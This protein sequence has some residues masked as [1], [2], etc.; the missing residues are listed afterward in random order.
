MKHIATLL[1]C[2]LILLVGCGGNSKSKQY[3]VGIDAS[4]HS[5]DLEGKENNVTAFSTDLLQEIGRVQKIF[6]SK[7][8]V[9][10]WDNLIPGLKNKHYDAIL[11][12]ITP[13]NFNLDTYDFSNVYLPTGPV[14]I[15]S[16]L[17][18]IT[19]LDEL[20][21]KEIAVQPGLSGINILEKYP[22]I[23]IRNYQSVPTALNDILDETVDGALVD[24]L[25]AYSYVQ[26]LYKGQLKIVTPPLNDAGLRFIMLHGA[27]KNGIKEFD[28]GLEK[29]KKSGVYDQLLKKWS[30]N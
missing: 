4:W 7:V 30:L 19:S 15:V 29:L 6:F 24:S 13:Y 1:I 12:S 3:L 21:G 25:L 9:S 2:S 5:V 20:K 22:G 27:E 18:S 26:E 16:T 23:L 28:A 8:T 11:S 14:L 17:S 10:S